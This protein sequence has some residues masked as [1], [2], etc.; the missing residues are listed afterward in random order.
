MSLRGRGQESGLKA[1]LLDW[2]KGR[3]GHYKGVQVCIPFRELPA[4]RRELAER[5]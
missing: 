4:A 5:R 1:A 3:I 2:C